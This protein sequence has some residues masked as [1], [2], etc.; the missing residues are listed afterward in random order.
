MTNQIKNASPHLKARLASALYF[1][2]LLTAISGESLLRGR[3]AYTAGEIAVVGMAAM[4]L[5]LYEIFKPVSQSVS[6]LAVFFNFVGLAFEALRWNPWGVDIAL[7]FAGL[8]HLLIGYLIVRSMFIPRILGASMTIAGLAWL[9]YL[10]PLVAHYLS[11][12]N[13]AAGLL[14]EGLFFL[15]LLVIGVN[16]AQWQETASASRANAA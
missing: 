10:S 9:T 4:T 12:Y 6:L 3:L 16:V 5:L 14:G 2:S 11:P 7:V 13:T 15:W 1:V 8:H